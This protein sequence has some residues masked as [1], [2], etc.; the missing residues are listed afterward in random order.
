MRK[1]G[2]SHNDI[3]SIEHDYAQHFDEQHYQMLRTLRDRNGVV[4]AFDKIFA[5]LQEMDLNGIYENLINELKSKDLIIKET[6][7]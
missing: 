4:V 7:D 1:C 6:E 5:G 2:L 3:R